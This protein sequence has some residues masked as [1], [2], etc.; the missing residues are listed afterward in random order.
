MLKVSNLSF[1]YNKNK[2]VLDDV[3]FDIKQGECVILLGPNGVGKTTLLSL[4][5]G[6]NKTKEGS[7]S[8]FDKDIKEL[9]AK[10]KADYISYV[11]QLISGNDL[12]VFDTVILGRLPY[13]KIYPNKND[14]N[15]T[16]EYISKFGLQELKDKQTNQ[17][18]GGERQ[19][20]SLVRGLIQESKLLIFDEPTNNLDINAEL[21]VLDII[22]EEKKKNKS[23]LI[24]MHDIN[25]ALAIGDKFIF[26]K[27]GKIYAICSKNEIKEAIIDEVYNV[28]SKIIKLEKGDYVI[29][30]K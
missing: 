26:L 21:R 16:N 1:S 8:Y 17:I 29:Y 5:L 3:S 6:N 20:V 19:I 22:K 25:Q 23:F 7:I 4:L 28:K 18:S 24:S 9:N 2:K 12:T 13:Y 14:I 30:E 15:L 27:N 10:E 11:P